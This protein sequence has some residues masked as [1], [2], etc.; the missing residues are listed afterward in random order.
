MHRSPYFF[1]W[2]IR[3]F[4]LLTIRPS[5]LLTFF[6]TP[7]PFHL[8]HFH[9]TNPV[10]FAWHSKPPYLSTL[11]RLVN[12]FFFLV[13]VAGLP[14]HL[15]HYITGDP[16]ILSCCGRCYVD[17]TIPAYTRGSMDLSS[18]SCL[19]HPRSCFSSFSS[20]T[21]TLP[22]P[23]AFFFFKAPSNSGA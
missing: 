23:I 14:L 20:G 2:S 8:M 11:L 9:W 3:P 4:Y 5:F 10:S 12:A 19:V 17:H 1:F 22:S 21:V 7:T 15:P 16:R 18:V 6:P 13:P